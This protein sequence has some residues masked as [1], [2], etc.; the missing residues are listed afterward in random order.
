MSDWKRVFA[1]IFTGQLFSTL[2]S[3]VVGYAVIFWLSIKTGSAQVLAYATIASLL[4]QLVLGMFSGVFVDRWNRKMIMII[5]DL[6]IALCTLA[7]AILFFINEVRISYIYIL[8]VMRSAGMAFHVPAL[9]ASIPLM[10]PE[11]QLMRIA[12]INNIIQAVSTIATPALAALLISLFDM[13]WIMLIDVA[14]A[15][16]ASI[17][18]MMVRIPDPEK[19]SNLKPHI[20]RELIE[21]MR[22]IYIKPGLKWMFILTVTAHVFIMPIAAMFPLMTLQHFSGTTY[23]MS[24]V[25]IAWGVGTLLGGTL[26]GYPWLGNYKVTLINLMYII[27]G[28]TIFTSGLL[29]P[30]GFAI[31]AAITTVGGISVA[32]YS[33]AF[34][35]LLQTMVES[36]AL[37]RVFSLY[38][39]LTLL[40]S[41]IGLMAT[42]FIADSIGIVNAFLIAGSA[43]GLMGAGAFFV[44][45][46]GRMVKSEVRQ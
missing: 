39:S 6:F 35:V 41:M 4:P 25:E 31:F 32:I 17:T 13:T 42:G 12:G 38:T 24:L 1:I 22:E 10:A 34:T 16:I 5:A 19:K 27:M 21:G 2:S 46:V 28:L 8:L 11:D 3:Y 23:M 30:S 36:S 7:I 45:E 15:L 33:G 44:P 20:F 37:G 14:G 29:P 18:L 9:Q 26:L 43:I 40:P